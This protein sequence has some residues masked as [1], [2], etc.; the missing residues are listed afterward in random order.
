MS[1]QQT[2]NPCISYSDKTHVLVIV[3]KFMS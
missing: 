3:I 2:H 1:K